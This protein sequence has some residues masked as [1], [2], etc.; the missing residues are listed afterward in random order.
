M[1]GRVRT[2]QSRV[3]RASLPELQIGTVGS[4]RMLRADFE[5]RRRLLD[6]VAD[7]GLDHLFLADHVSFFDGRGMDALVNAATL[8]AAHPTLRV[9]I[10]VYLLALRHPAPVA[11]QIASLCES[12]PGRLEVGVGVGGEDRH[13]IEICGVDPRTRGRRTDEALSVVR[14]LLSGQAVDHEGEFFALRDAR[15]LPAP[16]PPVRLVVGGRSAAAVRRVGRLGDGWLGAWCSPRRFAEVAAE[17]QVIASAEGRGDVDWTHGMQVWTGPGQDRDAARARL[18]R[19]M[20]DMYRVPFERFE[21]YSPFGP[22]EAIAEFLAPYVE[23]GC[24]RLNVMPV[25][26]SEQAGIDAI[27]SVARILRR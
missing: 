11:R 5:T 25:A 13:E 19:S 14:R 23:A 10:G 26:E 12:A 2:E 21:R 20:E 1:S 8:L 7:A 15:I 22:P 17:V 9:H 3:T 6:R 4:P 16:D 27:G 24:R 18:A